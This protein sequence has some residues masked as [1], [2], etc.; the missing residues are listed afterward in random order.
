[1]A[2]LLF[3]VASV[4]CYSTGKA[5][6]I[7][8]LES[9]GRAL[10]V[11]KRR[12]FGSTLPEKADAGIRQSGASDGEYSGSASRDHCRKGVIQEDVNELSVS[13]NLEA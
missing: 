10:P 12:C 4:T 7:P 8:V 2:A 1:M 13:V 3:R 5:D 9:A 11:R 6:I